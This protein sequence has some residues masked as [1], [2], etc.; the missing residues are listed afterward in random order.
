MKGYQNTNRNTNPRD[1]KTE[2]DHGQATMS[3]VR[4]GCSLNVE[5]KEMKNV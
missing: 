4:T 5:E 2:E 1:F 3:E